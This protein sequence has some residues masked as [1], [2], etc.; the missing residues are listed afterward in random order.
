MTEITDGGALQKEGWR[1]CPTCSY[2]TKSEKICC[3]EN[4]ALQCAC[5]KEKK[6][7]NQQK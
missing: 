7:V 5:L 2:M 3:K 4:P 1:K 6:N